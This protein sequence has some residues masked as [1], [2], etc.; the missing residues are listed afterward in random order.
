M[1][2]VEESQD[3]HD[4]LAGV[5][6]GPRPVDDGRDVLRPEDKQY[7]RYAY[8]SR[9]LLSVIQRFFRLAYLSLPTPDQSVDEQPEKRHHKDLVE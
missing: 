7:L 8:V 1:V 9:S 6:H 3:G 5:G 4:C 2:E